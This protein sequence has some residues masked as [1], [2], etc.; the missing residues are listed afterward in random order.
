MH[1]ANFGLI[2]AH[3]RPRAHRVKINKWSGQWAKKRGQT[4]TRE[5]QKSWSWKWK[6]SEKHH[7]RCHG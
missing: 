6:W 5:R 7:M 2:Y 1:L 4:P 3:K